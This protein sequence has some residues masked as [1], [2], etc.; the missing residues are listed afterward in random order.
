MD[1]PVAAP[2][3]VLWYGDQA[4]FDRIPVDIPQLLNALLSTG[5]IEIAKAFLPDW[6]SGLST[7]V[8]Q[9]CESLLDDLHNYRRIANLR[10]G[11]QKMKVLRHD[12]IAK[13]DKT[14]FSARLLQDSQQR[15]AAFDCFQ[16]RPSMKRAARNE[17]QVG[18]SI[19]TLQASGH[20]PKVHG[21]EVENR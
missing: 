9:L 2:F 1:T 18:S 19:P 4:A 3:R 7:L 6:R 21:D 20:S 12:H 5:D 15:I 13:D 11:D 8:K 10:F 14:V 17:V 16:P